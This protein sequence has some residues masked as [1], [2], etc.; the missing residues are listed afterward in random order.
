M[1]VLPR[2]NKEK[3]SRHGLWD[4]K[5]CLVFWQLMQGLCTKVR[6]QVCHIHRLSVQRILF[7][8]IHIP[9]TMTEKAHAAPMTGLGVFFNKKIIKKF[10]SNLLPERYF[11]RRS[12]IDRLE[13]GSTPEVGSSKTTT[14]ASPTKAMATDSFLCMPPTRGQ[15]HPGV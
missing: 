4:S 13:Y 5:L 15:I 10:Q 8:C 3:C 2:R 12:Q 6:S 1:I 11:S 7:V 9:L 14:F